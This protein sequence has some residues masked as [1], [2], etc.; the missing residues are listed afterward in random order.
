[1]LIKNTAQFFL[2]EIDLPHSYKNSL[3]DIEK[4]MGPNGEKFITMTS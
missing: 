3:I 1:M 2:D 4:C